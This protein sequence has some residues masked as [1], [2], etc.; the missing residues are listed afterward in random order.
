M[1]LRVD[2][3]AALAGE[4]GLHAFIIGLSK[5]ANLPDDP[6]GPHVPYDLGLSRLS[7]AALTAYRMFEWLSDNHD[8][9]PIK[10]ATCRLLLTP[11][12]PEIE[13]EPTL[14]DLAAPCTLDSF[15]DDAEGWR[16]DS[17]NHTENVTLFYFA[18]HGAQRQSRDHVLLLEDFAD[19]KGGILRNAAD[20]A[21][22]IGGMAPS[23]TM[24]EMARKQLYFIDACRITPDMFGQYENVNTTPFW[25]VEK[26]GEDDRFRPVFYTANPGAA[27]YG[28]K[29]EQSIFSKSLLECLKGGAGQHSGYND[30]GKPIWSVTVHSLAGALGYYLNRINQQLGIEQ[31]FRVDSLGVGQELV[32]NH[33]EHPPPVDILISISPEHAGSQAKLVVLNDDNSV[34][35]DLPAASQYPSNNALPAGFYRVDA[36]ITPPTPDLEGRMSTWEASPPS[37]SWPINVNKR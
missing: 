19:G 4:P 10:L 17:S 26:Y 3:R 24:P 21:Q 20:T 37:K 15:W 1:S 13:V 14:I 31:V 33:L 16:T 6:D 34:V 2:N 12:E 8:R 23:E 5:Y 7:S 9:L 30:Y 27:S 22:L 18:G 32:I 35:W 11:S 28:I 36:T 25:E 29:G